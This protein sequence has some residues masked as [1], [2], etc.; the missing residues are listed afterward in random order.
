MERADRL[1]DRLGIQLAHYTRFLRFDNE[2]GSKLPAPVVW[3]EERIRARGMEVPPAA[4]A[5]DL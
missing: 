1:I 2:T 5:A 4:G 3:F